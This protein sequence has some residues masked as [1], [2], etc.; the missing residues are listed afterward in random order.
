MEPNNHVY[1]LSDKQQLAYMALHSTKS[2]FNR[3]LFGGAAGGGKSLLGCIFEITRRLDYPETRG[4]IGRKVRQDLMKSTFKT[5]TQV[6][7]KIAF[8]RIGPMKYNGQT[9][10]VFFPNGS[11]IQFLHLE[12]SPNDPEF[13]RLGSY[14]FTDGFI[15][16]VGEC[17]K[18]AIDVIYSR[19]RHNLINDKKALL[20]ASNPSYGWLKD[21]WVSKPDGTKIELPYNWKYIQAKV[22]DNPDVKFR[23]EYIRTLQEMPEYHRLRLLDGDWDYQVNNAPYYPQW[24][25][26]F[27]VPKLEYNP[28]KPLLLSFDFNYS[29]CTAVLIQAFD[30][31]LN[32]MKVIQAEGGTMP[33]IKAIKDYLNLIGWK[34]SY[35]VTGDSSGHKRDTRS[36]VETDY[37]LIQKEMKI[38]DGWISYNQR[39]NMALD[40]SRDLI[41][42]GFHLGII[43]ISR[44]GCPELIQDL[45]IA[46][47]LNDKTAEFKKDRDRYKL[48]VLDAFRYGFHHFIKSDDD[49]RNFNK[50]NI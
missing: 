11:E 29:P 35:R 48:D 31:Y 34:G 43:R 8:P 9:D 28:N 16:E 44:E 37:M 33:L 41:N 5:F 45:N 10:T 14:E 18:N 47:P 49:C 24:S 12:E 21:T 38:P 40:R 17:S 20:L 23:D 6:Y 15:D 25:A 1:E 36:G 7:N 13:Q 50:F 39:S 46:K 42:L 2:P 30:G 19:I 3:V 27:I 22:S 4:F 26:N 32:C